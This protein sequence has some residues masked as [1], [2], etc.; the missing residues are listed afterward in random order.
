[1]LQLQGLAALP[2]L[3]LVGYALS[4]NRRAISWRTVL[5]ALAL[6]FV[7]AILVLKSGPVVAVFDFLAMI[8][9]RVIGFADAGVDFLFG[10]VGNPSGPWGFIFA[11]RV[12]PVIVFFSSLMAVLYHLGVMQR[13]VA[14]FAWVLRKSLGITGAEALSASANIF[15]GQ[16]E[17]PL[18]VKP[19]I[20]GMTRSQLTA[21]MVG[22]FATIAGS[23][24][25]AYIGMLGEAYGT[26]MATAAAAGG[27]AFSPDAAKTAAAAAGKELFAKHLL[28]A[29]VMSAPAGLLF[30][31]LFVPETETPRSES[32]NALLADERTTTNIV[33]AAAAGATDGL[34]LAL[35]VAAML[36]AF[37]AL[38]AMI[39]Y[40]LTALSQWGP[41]ADLARTLGLPGFSLDSLLGLILR[42]IAWSMGVSWTDSVG[43]GGLL[44]TQIIATEFVAYT[45]L[46]EAIQTGTLSPRSAQI[47]T[48][49]LCGFANV[50]SI[51]IQIGGLAAM[52]PERR[53]DLA[54]LA[55]RAMLAGALACWMTGAIAG[56][57]I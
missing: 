26:M 25:A 29:S 37:V 15:V 47:T 2:L 28:T 16:T 10:K 17:A 27:E 22:G 8:V 50:A 36:V 45:R 56:I 46:A 5:G 54:A 44:G 32:V 48:Y 13:V 57:F 55:P 7:I 3:M 30:A 34:K 4:S 31:K 41:A 12:L 38:L 9:A 53:S 24:M 6:Q 18:T 1:M 19:Y 52:A 35:N 23:V 42:P 40:P 20:A 21:I 51:G 49:A 33:D 43:V 14:A 11:V 39:N